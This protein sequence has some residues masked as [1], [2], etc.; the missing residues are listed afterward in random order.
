MKKLIITAGYMGS[1]SSAA[2]D[3]ISE[4]ENV[5]NKYGDFEY[6]FLNCPNGVFDLEDK[7]LKNNNSFRSDEALHTFKDEMKVLYGNKS[8][9]PANYR[10]NLGVEFV[11]Y[12]NDY[13]EELTDFKMDSFWYYQEKP[14][15]A[16]KFKFFIY[17]VLK[18]LTRRKV[19]IKKPLRYDQMTICYKTP[20]EFYSIT[21]KFIKRVIGLLKTDDSNDL[22][23]DQLL[24]PH[25][26]YRLNNYFDDNVRVIVVERDP[27]DVFL[28]NKYIWKV[29][30]DSVPFS[31]NVEDFCK[32]YDMLR[33]SENKINDKKILRIYFEDLIYNYEET[34]KKIA[35]FLDYDL[36][37]QTKKLQRFNPDVSINNTRVFEKNKNYTEET[38]YIEQHL[39]E[40]LYNF[41]KYL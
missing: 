9:W 37:K 34:L 41:D 30:G 21:K 18:K 36:R 11:D 25:N 3:V 13:C 2:T 28:S 20:D 10:K 39:K 29:N 31:Y 26:L 35:E 1:G 16:I 27:R 38:K 17:R 33:K 24:L 23:M 19:Y 5:D 12:V 22:L 40:Y 8:W 6:V 15:L 7:L 32:Q 4:F 14:T